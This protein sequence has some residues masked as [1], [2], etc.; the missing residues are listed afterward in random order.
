MN[1]HLLVPLDGA[2]ESEGVLSEVQRSSD[3]QDPV[4]FLHVLPVHHAPAGGE[5]AQGI[6]LHQQA[7]DYLKV[8]RD[9]L[10]P[11]QRGLDLIRAGNPAEEILKAALELNIHR[12]AMTTHGRTGLGRL[13][14]GSVA[15]EVVRKSQLPVLLTRPGM[16]ELRGRYRKILIAV[17]G[18]ETVAEILETVR[19]FATDAPLEIILFSA[20]LA[21]QDPAPQWALRIPL[22][23]LLS[24][25]GRI[26]SLADSLEKEGY[27][28][29]PLVSVGDPVDEILE[30]ARRHE[31]DLIALATH[32]RS[33]WER[34]LE[35]SVAEGVLHRSP[36]AVLLRKP[37]VVHQPALAGGPHA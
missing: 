11:H 35:G 31:V 34:I 24:P 4:H 22:A 28:A 21:S 2:P 37:L 16:A 7:A 27:A 20:A 12:I 19:S 13:L 26:Q 32:G 17:E 6:E 23:P 8:T 36:V 25:L 1:K 29:W 18:H 5:A 15:A 30:Q 10:L 14:L 33:G 3:L 9:R